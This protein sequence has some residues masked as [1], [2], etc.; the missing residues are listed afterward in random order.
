M[1]RQPVDSGKMSVPLVATDRNGLTF[2]F[3]Q[4]RG[5]TRIEY[6][7]RQAEDHPRSGRR[8][9]FFMPRRPYAREALAQPGPNPVKSILTSVCAARGCTI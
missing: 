3:R 2:M 5:I 1:S 9:N 7:S 6:M 8:D 4:A